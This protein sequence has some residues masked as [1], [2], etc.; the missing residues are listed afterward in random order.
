[1]VNAETLRKAQL[2]MVDILVVI[3]DICKKHNIQYFLAYGTLLG[4]VR[5]KGFIPWDDDCDICMLR[6]DFERFIAIAQKE[7]PNNLFLQNH[8]TDP[9]FPRTMTKVRM[10]NTLLVEFDESENE[11]Y[12]QGIFV[13]VFIW[14]YH[15][16]LVMSILDKIKIVNVWKYKRKMYPKGSFKRVAMQVVVAPA[17]LVYST[18]MKL[19]AG[20]AVLVRKNK[21]LNYVGQEIKACDG[22]FYDKNVIFPIKRDLVF[23][24][25]SFAVPN[26]WDSTL[27]QMYGDYM[28][29]PKEEDRYWHAK[30][31]EV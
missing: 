8:K 2:K 15:H 29:L 22:V 6:E 7:L 9:Y 16:P 5:H 20:V 28:K 24:G 10:K 25:K 11:K 26:N 27:T 31:I 23:E 14:D 4:A 21:K 12:H 30:K 3:D 18:I 1:M 17:Y 19:L 13:D